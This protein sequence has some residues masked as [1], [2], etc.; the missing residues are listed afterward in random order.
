MTRD[1]VVPADPA[2]RPVRRRATVR[3]LVCDEADRLLLFCDSDPGTG[4]Q[5]WITPGGG[6][7]DG[8]TELA[9]VRR[10]LAEETGLQVAPEQVIGPIAR[11]RV[12]HGYSDQV[13]DQHDTFFAVRVPRFAV[14]TSGFTDEE[15]VTV[16]GSR[17]WTVAE[18]VASPERVWPALL[19]DL[20]DL[21]ERPEDWPVAL[22]TVEESSVAV[23]AD[24][25]AGPD[26]TYP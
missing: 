3:V 24:L 17:W 23:G 25:I 6:I 1:F 15:L 2:D 14:D 13:V 22:P 7:D 11:R 4:Q 26:V 20:V 5:W 8:E 16:Q 19:P 21:L 10:E 18:T 12:W 9:A